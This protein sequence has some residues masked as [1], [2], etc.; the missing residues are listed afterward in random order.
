MCPGGRIVASVNEPGLVCTNGMSNSKHSSAWATAAVV[1][2]L[3]PEHFG[4]G[5]FDGVR[6]QREI[7]RLFFERGGGDYTAPAQRASD[8]VAGRASASVRHSTYTFGTRPERVDLLLPPSVRDA[9]ARAIARF[10]GQIRGFAGDEGL[11]VGVESRSSSPVRMPRD[12]A[13]R[14]AL[15]TANLYPVGEGAGYAGGIMSAA[16]DGANSALA[17][18]RDGV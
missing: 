18:V 2:T 10:D 3:G 13:T 17:I 11:L 7:E 9:L 15:G 5:P 1:A 6:F 16:L 4:R 8:F 12:P 14:R